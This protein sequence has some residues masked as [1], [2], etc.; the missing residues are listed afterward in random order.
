[1]RKMFRT[2][3]ARPIATAITALAIYFVIAIFL[4]SLVADPDDRILLSEKAFWGD[5]LTI[6]VILISLTL[7]PLLTSSRKGP[8]VD[9]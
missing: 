3:L 9:S 1:M 5:G 6:F 8:G 4:A 7:A 2:Y